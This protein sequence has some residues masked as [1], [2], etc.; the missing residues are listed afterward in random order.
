MS[1]KKPK[2]KAE[3]SARSKK[4]RCKKS[5]LDKS[6]RLKRKRHEEAESDEGERSKKLRHKE[7]ES[8]KI[9]LTEVNNFGDWYPVFG[10]YIVLCGTAMSDS[11]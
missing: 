10:T 5:D 8:D 2:H 6:E 7:R 1:E 11:I 4:R 9:T 3:A